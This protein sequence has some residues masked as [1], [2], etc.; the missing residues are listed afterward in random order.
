MNRDP[1]RALDHA[2][3]LV[4]LLAA[5][6]A[7]LWY[8]HACADNARSA[9]PLQVQQANNFDGLIVGLYEE[10]GYGPTV[11]GTLQPAASP[12]PFYPWLLAQLMVTAPELPDLHE[13][14][15]WCQAALGTLTA[16]LLFLFGRAALGGRAVG[17][18]AGLL[19]A[20]HPCW[21]INVAEIDD[22]V[23]ATFLLAACLLCGTLSLGESM[24][25]AWLFGLSLAA[26]ALTR[27]AL[28]PFAFIA[29]LWLLWRCRTL[30]HGSAPAL[31]AVVGFASGLT[32][33]AMRNYR[34]FND[35]Y[36]VVDS[37]YYHLWLGNGPDAAVGPRSVVLEDGDEK[38]SLG[39][40][41]PEWL[42]VDDRS[43]AHIIFGELR[44]HPADTLR[45]RIWA[46]LD[47]L[48]G[49]RWFH[50]G[51]LW[52]GGGEDAWAKCPDW[53]A[54][55]HAAILTGSLLAM[56]LLAPLGWR[57]S[58]AH[59][60]FAAPSAV[61]LIWVPLPYILS[62]AE[63]L[64]GPRL[65]LDAVLLCYTALALVTFVRPASRGAA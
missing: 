34:V 53:L 48:F 27:A 57:W 17:L 51:K 63:T 2:C 18:I 42:A 62:H 4:V 35:V 13:R 47:F 6:G 58:Y 9:G 39:G 1:L 14:V 10:R 19:A 52:R 21:I 46:G 23:L 44:D 38:P 16:A 40:P 54:R 24:L 25:A 11:N 20:V 43:R 59:R 60:D 22:G 15:R 50:D 29:L 5:A 12:A 33:W 64:P 56:L 36:P 32:P 28:L 8:L 41:P 3:L 26:L 45:R 65:P 30:T 61:A 37:T 49:S 31:L 55:S 7:R